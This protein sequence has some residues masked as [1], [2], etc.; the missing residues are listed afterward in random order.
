MTT[1]HP[2]VNS[3]V[4]SF[5]NKPIAGG[6][7]GGH[8]ICEATGP[9]DG[10]QSGVCSRDHSTKGGARGMR[11]S[12]DFSF[13]PWQYTANVLREAGVCRRSTDHHEEYSKRQ[14]A[15]NNNQLAVNSSRSFQA[16]TSS[17]S[18]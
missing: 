2:A 16:R 8:A 3:G 7:W 15:E 5:Q 4:P 18:G 9:I 6:W 17:R 11:K 12:E 13:V 10:I 1:A 14:S